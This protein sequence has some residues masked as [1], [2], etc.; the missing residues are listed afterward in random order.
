MLRHEKCPIVLIPLL[1]RLCELEDIL[2]IAVIGSYAKGINTPQSDVDLLL[3]VSD[4]F[5]INNLRIILQ[6]TYDNITLYNSDDV[7]QIVVQKTTISF[8]VRSIDFI[9]YLRRLV[10]GHIPPIEIKPWVIGGNIPEVLISDIQSSVILL[11]R[12]G[13]FNQLSMQLQNGY[14][15]SMK[16]IMIPLL[17]KEIKQKASLMLRTENPVLKVIGFN[18]VLV[19]YI[20]IV[21]LHHNIMNFGI[22]HYFQNRGGEINKIIK[23]R[24]FTEPIV[25]PDIINAELNDMI[26]ELEVYISEY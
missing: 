23:K 13:E 25:D 24:L 17:S 14:P 10:N 6:R 15:D 2:V 12:E 26:K 8:A 9:G 16:R 5:K 20:R 11:D 3:I 4:S 18:E 21:A 19:Q 22:K 1:D 7:Y